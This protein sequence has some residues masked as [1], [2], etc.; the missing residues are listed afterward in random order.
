L[1]KNHGTRGLNIGTGAWW[2]REAAMDV[3]KKML[4]KQQANAVI[5]TSAVFATPV[6]TNYFFQH[7]PLCKGLQITVQ[8]KA[9]GASYRYEYS[10]SSA[11]D[12]QIF[13][14][15]L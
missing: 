15:S 9:E 6:A 11:S 14:K 7:L 8:K 13:V 4:E 3:C 5:D 10:S 12:A 1:Q 2:Q